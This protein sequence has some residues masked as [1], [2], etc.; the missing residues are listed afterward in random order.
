MTLPATD[1]DVDAA[2]SVA[3]DANNECISRLI[4]E[5]VAISSTGED[6]PIHRQKC[7]IVFSPQD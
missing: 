6:H 3:L 4:R 2:V 7:G 5:A 1:G